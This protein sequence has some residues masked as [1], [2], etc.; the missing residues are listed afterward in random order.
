MPPPAFRGACLKICTTRG[1]IASASWT[2]PMQLR[3]GDGK[4]NRPE[5]QL[6]SWTWACQLVCALI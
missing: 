1:Q 4:A 3:K 6:R 5:A 2:H